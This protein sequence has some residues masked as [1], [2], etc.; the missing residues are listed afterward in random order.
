[1]A[2][3]PDEVIFFDASGSYDPDG[4]IVSYLWDFGDGTTGTGISTQ[5]AY[6]QDGTYVVILM[7]T[8]DFGAT[9][10]ASATKTVRN[11]EPVAFFNDSAEDVLIGEIIFFDASGSYDPDGT[12]VS[13]LWDFGDGTTKEG[14]TV[15]HSY[16]EVGNYT[17][18]LVITDDDGSSSSVVVE[19]TVNEESVMSLA[20]LSLVGLG[21]AALTATLLYGL[22]VRRKKKKKQ[23]YL[24][25]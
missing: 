16:S 6:S 21:I 14:V 19:K 5:H 7:V 25:G 17:V 18:T 23:T 8:D 13:Y 12:I 10:T 4:T 24:D 3:N 1:G 15:D 20:V 2:V 9:D 22:I 11:L